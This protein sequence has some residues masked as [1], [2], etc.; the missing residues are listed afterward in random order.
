MQVG[1]G[2]PLQVMQINRLADGGPSEAER[3]GR[4]HIGD[5]IV[6]VDGVSVLDATDRRIVL[7]AIMRKRPVTVEFKCAEPLFYKVLEAATVLQ[8]ASLEA[9]SVFDRVVPPNATVA[10]LHCV[11]PPGGEVTFAKLAEAD[12]W[13]ADRSADSAVASV[14]MRVDGPEPPPPLPTPVFDASQIRIFDLQQKAPLARE[15]LVASLQRWHYSDDEVAFIVDDAGRQLSVEDVVMCQSR[16]ETIRLVLVGSQWDGC[17]LS[18][19]QRNGISA[20]YTDSCRI[21]CSKPVPMPDDG[22]GIECRITAFDSSGNPQTPDILQLAQD[23]TV[24]RCVSVAQTLDSRSFFVENCQGPDD[25]TPP[26][27]PPAVLSPRSAAVA[28]E[29]DKV[30]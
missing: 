15:R 26:S 6:A 3:C 27:P 16:L 28:V 21:H 20:Q 29:L 5:T 7:G 13:I 10:V 17:P 19:P 22:G 24:V 4:V 23:G 8:Q 1:R 25:S 12:G 9:P 14:L 11:T 30:C 18:V 2:L